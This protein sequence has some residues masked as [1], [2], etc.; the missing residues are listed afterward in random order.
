MEEMSNQTEALVEAAVR[1]L[2]TADP[3]EKARLGDVI[4]TK[5]LQGVISL[6]YHPSS[7]IPV[8]DRPAR[9]TNVCL[10]PRSYMQ[11][12]CSMKCL[13]HPFVAGEAGSAQ[14]HAEAGKSWEFTEPAGYRA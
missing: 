12:T 4:A 13:T 5:W 8:P 14:S 10:L 7:R 3:F 6:P 1:V 11:T 9:L 2:N